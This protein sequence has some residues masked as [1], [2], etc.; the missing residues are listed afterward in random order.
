MQCKAVKANIDWVGRRLCV[1]VHVYTATN[2]V[3]GVWQGVL[4]ETC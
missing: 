2:H 1:C 3:A 4:G